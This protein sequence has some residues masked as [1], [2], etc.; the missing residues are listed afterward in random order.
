VKVPSG[1]AQR[2]LKSRNA[3]SCSTLFTKALKSEL[4]YGQMDQDVIVPAIFDLMSYL[5]C[6]I[7]TVCNILSYRW[8]R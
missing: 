3:I 5:A 2:K 4:K 6:Q 8:F 1:F 7:E